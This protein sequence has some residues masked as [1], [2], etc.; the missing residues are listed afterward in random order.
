MCKRGGAIQRYKSYSRP[1]MAVLKNH[2]GCLKIYFSRNFQHSWT[3]RVSLEKKCFL[4]M[5][6]IFQFRFDCNVFEKKNS[7]FNNF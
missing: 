1:Y 2:F 3:K 6:A 5:E 4:F 7:F